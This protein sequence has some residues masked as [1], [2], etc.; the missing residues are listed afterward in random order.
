MIVRKTMEEINQSLTKEEL[1]MLEKAKSMPITFDEDCPE[2]TE[3][4]LKHMYRARDGQPVGC[5]E[6]D[7]EDITMNVHTWVVV[8][9]QYFAGS[10]YREFLSCVLDNALHNEEIIKNSLSQGAK[11]CGRFRT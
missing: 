5:T 4:Q 2:L 6:D 1:E 9:A 11:S 10:K 7:T 8:R 3:E